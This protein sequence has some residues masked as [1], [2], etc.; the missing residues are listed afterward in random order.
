MRDFRAVFGDLVIDVPAWE[1]TLGG[2]GIELTRTEFQILVALASRPRQV[3]TDD[4]LVR[5]VWGDGWFGDD[6][7]LAVHVSKL[8]RKLG[9][10]GLRPRFIRTIRGVGYRF[11]PGALGGP[12]RPAP[13]AERPCEALRRHP[14]AVEVRTDGELRV[15]SVHPPEARVLGF[16]SRDLRGRYFP[17]VEG[18]PWDDHA[19]ALEGIR[20][21][22]S[23]GVR[24][25]FSRHTVRRCDGT[26]AQADVATCID[27]DGDGHLAELRFV[28]LELDR[29]LNGSAVGG[30]L[31][32]FR[33]PRRS[34]PSVT[35]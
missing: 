26:L 2:R 6:N 27:L 17:V 31:G 18:R 3:I 29:P 13:E 11:D 16:E 15:V 20:V 9:E 33:T 5:T 34:S 19:S 21:L 12:E 22:I 1:V 7:N 4:D 24:D 32:E 28:V 35:A 8:R 10:S 14:G 23:S 30:G 25:W